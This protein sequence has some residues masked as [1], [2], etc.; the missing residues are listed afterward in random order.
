MIQEIRKKI[1]T[2]VAI[3]MISTLFGNVYADEVTPKSLVVIFGDSITQGYNSNNPVQPINP[4]DRSRVDYALPDRLLTNMLA[5]SCRDNLVENWG[6]GGS[7]S[8]NGATRI[9]GN[10]DTS[11][12]E[13]SEAEGY[14]ERF[15]LIFYGT[16]DLNYKI[17]NADT[18][19]YIEFM[20]EQ[21]KIKGFKPVVATLIKRLDQPGKVETRNEFIKAAAQAEPAPVIDLYS[22]FDNDPR[23]YAGLI[24]PDLIHPND[25][26]LELIAQQWFN[27]LETQTEP[28]CNNLIISPILYL[29]LD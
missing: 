14:V 23:G 28:K 5:E 19:T 22:V 10:L 29:L 17:S 27:Y 16:N 11:K 2:I 15:I 3:A 4:M 20:I 8:L 18:R 1:R 26:G 13:Y 9:R 21:A 24:D 25:Q 6:W 12:A 7:S